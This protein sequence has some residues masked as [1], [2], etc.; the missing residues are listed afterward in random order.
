M[1]HRLVLLLAEALVAVIT[2]LRLGIRVAPVEAVAAANH[3]ADSLPMVSVS[4]GLRANSHTRSE[5]V[6]VA[7]VLVILVV[8]VMEA[9]GTMDLKGEVVAE[10]VA[11]AAGAL[12][13]VTVVDEVSKAEVALAVEA[14]PFRLDLDQVPPLLLVPHADEKVFYVSLK[15]KY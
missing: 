1:E 7:E 5:V 13:V 15:N 14:V 11:V 2:P 8:E 4:L 12:E 9:L 10:A 6:V 3:L